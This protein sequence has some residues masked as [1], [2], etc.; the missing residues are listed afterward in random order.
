MPGEEAVEAEAT[1]SDDTH[2]VTAGEVVL[3]PVFDVAGEISLPTG[4]AI[5]VSLPVGT[6][7]SIGEQSVVLDDGILELEA[8]VIDQYEIH[9]ALWPFI[10]KTVIVSSGVQVD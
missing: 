7:V 4:T 8:D 3:R 9:L 10:S 6:T 1:V 2:Y 5:S